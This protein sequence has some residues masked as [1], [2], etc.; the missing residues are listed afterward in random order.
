MRLMPMDPSA[1]ALEDCQ[2]LLIHLHQDDNV[3][4]WTSKEYIDV[5]GTE[6]AYDSGL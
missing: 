2:D 4:G 5:R 6:K 1:Y 3:G